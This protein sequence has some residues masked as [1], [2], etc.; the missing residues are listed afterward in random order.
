MDET[1]SDENCDWRPG[2]DNLALHFIALLD[3]LACAD[4]TAYTLIG[5]HGTELI[6]Y[7]LWFGLFQQRDN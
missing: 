6:S 1:S 3:I 5:G 2:L 4:N 7:Q